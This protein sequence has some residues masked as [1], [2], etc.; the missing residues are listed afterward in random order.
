[1]PLSAI[2]MNVVRS[3]ILGSTTRPPT[4]YRLAVL[5]MWCKAIIFIHIHRTENHL[6]VTK[7]KRLKLIRLEFLKY[8]DIRWLVPVAE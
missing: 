4:T 2:H 1:V 6:Y 5:Q 3:S 7:T 8:L